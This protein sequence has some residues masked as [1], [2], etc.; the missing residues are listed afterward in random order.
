MPGSDSTSCYSPG[1]STVQ[2]TGT[3]ERVQVFTSIAGTTQTVLR[4]TAQVGAATS[5]SLT[6]DVYTSASGQYDVFLL[7]PGCV[8]MQDCDS[9]TSVDVTINP[10]GSLSPVTKTVSQQNNEDARL[11]VYS[12]PIIPSGDDYTVTVKLALSASPTGTGSGGQYT[13]IADRISLQLTSASLSGNDTSGGGSGATGTRRGF[14]VYEWPLN[15]SPSGVNATG[16]I[17]NNTETSVTS[18]AFGLFSGMGNSTSSALQA[19]VQSIATVTKDQV[20]MAGKFQLSGGISNIV[21]SN[22][23][24]LSALANNG[25][26]GA[27]SSMVLYG[28]SLFVGG[29]F[30]ST[31]DGSIG[32]NHIAW[33][34]IANSRWS[35]LGGGVDGPVSSLGLSNGHLT[36]I[37]NFTHTL[38]T[39]STVLTASGLATWDISGGRWSNSGGLLVGR[40]S[41]VANA[42]T[43]NDNTEYLAGSVNMYL[44]YGADGAASMSNG[45]NGQAKITPLGARLDGS[46]SS[47]ATAAKRSLWGLN[48]RNILAPR[49]QT[50]PADQNAPAPSVL[51]GVFWTN[52]TNSHQVMII[53]GNFTVPGS[54]T[55]SLGI[56]DP[57]DESVIGLQGSQVNGVVRSLLVVG[58]KL[59]VGGEFTLQGVDGQSFAVYDLTSQSWQSGVGGLTG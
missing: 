35:T 19:S 11:L 10:G 4:S 7:V 17:P 9:R 12:G 20:F 13:I 26:N 43:S 45:D 21:L 52:T 2:T 18:A 38:I 49:Q 55:V 28:N 3:W 41:I 46:A 30:T 33:Y 15:N 14:G 53:G 22:S 40:M 8:N 23:G 27:V 59:Y 6:W 31:S 48:L 34:D 42:T 29:S 56:Y 5:P 44:K 51:S 37:G 39:S 1:P 58:T 47:S 54:S 50:I 25:L 32:L 16:V 36:V 24:S 57:E